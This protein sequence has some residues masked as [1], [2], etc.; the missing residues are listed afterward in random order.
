MIREYCSRGI[1]DIVSIGTDKAF[2]AVESEIKYEPYNITLTTCDANRH[3]EYVE[4]MIRFVKEQ[5]RT[6]RIAMPYKTIPKR[7][8]IE[9]V[10]RV[11]ILMV[12]CLGKVAFTVSYL[13]GKL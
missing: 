8:T 10:H 12:H 6:V 7:M 3:V 9:M 5:I 1:F 2:D 13:L 11:I 4:R